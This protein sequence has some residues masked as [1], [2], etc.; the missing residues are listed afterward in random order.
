MHKVIK[1]GNLICFLVLSGYV[2]CS[3]ANQLQVFFGSWLFGEVEIDYHGGGIECLGEHLK[4]M[5]QVN[6]PIEQD[7]S[8]FLINIELGAHIVLEL[9]SLVF[10][11]HHEGEAV[12]EV[13]VDKLRILGLGLHVVYNH[14]CQFHLFV[15]LGLGLADG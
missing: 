8:H 4:L 13:V 6:D 1:F 10:L 3:S 11:L 5:M 12:F 7:P 14:G 15:F 2:Q 9:I